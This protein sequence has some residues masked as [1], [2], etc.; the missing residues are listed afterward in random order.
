LNIETLRLGELDI[1][2]TMTMALM[3]VKK[4]VG[5]VAWAALNA[6]EKTAPAMI[7]I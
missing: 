7:Y 3:K 1:P 2:K 4:E 6:E 5:D